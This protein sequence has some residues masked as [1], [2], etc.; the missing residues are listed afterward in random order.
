MTLM[1]WEAFLGLHPE[2]LSLYLSYPL[3]LYAALRHLG[4]AGAQYLI[5]QYLLQLCKLRQGH[6]GYRGGQFKNYF[7]IQRH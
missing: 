7:K 6:I 3:L 4:P 1:G 2:I 5:Q